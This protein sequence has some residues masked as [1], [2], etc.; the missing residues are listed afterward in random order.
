[1]TEGTGAEGTDT[2]ATGAEAFA[3]GKLILAG[4]HAVV[5]GYPAIAVAVDRGTRVR[6]RRRPGPSRVEAS[7]LVTP[8]GAERPFPA[9]DRLEPALATVMPADGVGLALW[10]N[11]PIGRGMGS[12]ASLAVAAVRALGTLAG[13][14]ADLQT[15]ITRG[16]AVERLFHGTPSG[17]DHTVS[18]RGGVN[19]YRRAGPDGALE[20]RQLAPRPL[21]LVVLDSGS[22]GNT[23]EL[24]A[25]VRARRPGVDP[26]LER[27]GALVGELESALAGDDLGSIGALLTENH[28]LLAQI[29]VSSP[30]LD[31]LVALALS[32]GAVGA[33]LAGAGGGGVVFALVREPE[34]VLRAAHQRDISAFS[35]NLFHSE[36]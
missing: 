12:S 35:V 28:R 16:F 25:G 10:S 23:A 15:C 13:Q 7:T 8:E 6:A 36:L 3:P 19:W 32:A 18:A 31:E 14:P 4:E 30:M 33:K 26:L 24:V 20:L 22:A 34:P 5:Y 21:S 1:M 11:L 27:I 29:G 2:G 9:D 17:L